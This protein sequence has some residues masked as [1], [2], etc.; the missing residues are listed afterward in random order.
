MEKK[1]ISSF[2]ISAALLIMIVSECKDTPKPLVAP[3]LNTLNLSDISLTTAEGGGAILS[4]GGSTVTAKGVC[5]SLD[6][7]PTM[8][9]A[10]TT[11][12]KGDGDF[13][14]TLIGLTPNTTY[15]VR[16]YATNSVGTSYGSDMTFMTYGI[17]DINGSRYHYVTIGTQDWMQ[18]NLRVKK[19]NDG[20]DIP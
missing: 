1:S 16:A 2:W 6:E 20:S 12:G 15:H 4:N 5:W 7:T 3:T 9:D 10:K 18:E 14:S 19:Y 17:E 11:D 8:D 13:Q